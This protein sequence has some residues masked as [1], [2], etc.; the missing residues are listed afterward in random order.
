FSGSSGASVAVGLSAVTPASSWVGVSVVGP[1][2]VSISNSTVVGNGGVQLPPLPMS[3]TYAIL[4]S[5][6]TSLSLN[7]VGPVSNALTLNGA[8]TNVTI[9]VPGQIASLT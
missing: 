6:A 7:L 8:P 9:G 2:G 5:G 4:V 1:N 3:G